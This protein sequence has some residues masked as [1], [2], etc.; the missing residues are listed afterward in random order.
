MEVLRILERLFQDHAPESL[1]ALF[2]AATSILLFYLIWLVL[3]HLFGLQARTATQE[4]DQDQTTTALIDALV[5]ALVT[6]SRHL[7]TTMDGI[8]RE[9][10]KR[11]EQN[12]VI[13]AGLIHRMEETP[14]EVVQLLQP[15]FEYLHHEMT[16]AEQRIIDKMEEAAVRD[17]ATTDAKLPGRNP[18]LEPRAESEEEKVSR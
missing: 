7:R 3:R 14:H 12:S 11:N 16:Q 1:M 4:A 6:E 2:G 17:I 5:T 13:L 9:A 10:L 18:A 8:L 15:E